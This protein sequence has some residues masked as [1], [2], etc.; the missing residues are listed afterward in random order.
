MTRSNRAKAQAA[1]NDK[2][3]TNSGN[4]STQEKE[5]LKKSEA[6]SLTRETIGKQIPSAKKSLDWDEDYATGFVDTRKR[7]ART[8]PETLMKRLGHKPASSGSKDVINPNES[9]TENVETNPRRETKEETEKRE[10]AETK[11]CLNIH[12]SDEAEKSSEGS[13]EDDSEEE[14]EDES[15][16]ESEDENSEL[17]NEITSIGTRLDTMISSNSVDEGIGLDLMKTL[18]NLPMSCEILQVTRIGKVVN[19]FRR[20]CLSSEAATFGRK[21]IETW[22]KLLPESK[23]NETKPGEVC[24]SALPTTQIIDTNNKKN[25]EAQSGDHEIEPDI[26]TAIMD[27]LETNE[28]SSEIKD[29][30]IYIKGTHTDITRIRPASV[31]EDLQGI[32]QRRPGI[33]QSNN[34]CLR[35]TC[36]NNYEKELLIK[37]QFIA[38]H[39]VTCTEPYGKSRNLA[40]ISNRGIIFDVDVEVTIDEIESELGV[41][42]RRN[43]RRVNGETINTR[44]VILF[45]EGEMPGFVY[46]GWK[47]Y[48]VSVYIPE[49]I[50]C[51]HCQGYGHKANSC[52][53]RLRCPICSKNHSYEKCPNKN[54]NKENQKA[55]C[56]NCN[57]NHPAS[58]KGCTRYQ[59][60]K[61]IIKIQ[62]KEKLSYTEAVKMFKSENR[63]ADRNE[64][65]SNP[66]SS[67]GQPLKENSH[68][69]GPNA[70]SNSKNTSE[71]RHPAIEQNI[72]ISSQAEKEN[73]KKCVNVD[74][75]VHF[76][77]S[78]GTILRGENAT[79]ELIKHINQM[80]DNFLESIK[81]SQTAD[82]ITPGRNICDLIRM[83]S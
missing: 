80:V 27:T 38:G 37:T 31:F 19:D 61:S 78:I 49:P 26:Q 65:S 83:K 59:E 12:Y 77:K 17:V 15:E 71:D 8:P 11:E 22:R 60:E 34:R 56:P 64:Q 1:R 5:K 66:N 55:V 74:I 47:R 21:L 76:A 82:T 46:F 2:G 50:R 43:T 14:S 54:E 81:Q 18:F 48:R 23:V 9:V 75:L 39:Q 79:V 33:K 40:N 45:F 72:V 41:K 29:I 30:Y 52:N 28:N 25:D 20:R 67:E 70:N 32:L 13:S 3:N 42:A 51:Y 58:Y 68:I 53:A 6:E 63:N 73:P 24:I 16:K 57:N 36:L 4:T 35:V 44:Q 7:V 62:T 10:I 69:R